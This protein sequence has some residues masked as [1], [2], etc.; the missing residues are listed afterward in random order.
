MAWNFLNKE[1]ITPM[2]SLR[3]GEEKWGQHFSF[4]SGLDDLE[5]SEAPF[6]ILGVEEDFGVLGNHGVGGTQ[7]AWKN[8]LPVLVNVQENQFLSGKDVI[9]LGSYKPTK[10]Y[11]TLGLQATPE[12]ARKAVETVDAEVGAAVEKIVGAGKIP[13]LI[14]GGHNNAYPLLAGTS[15]GLK[16]KI[17]AINLDPHADFR[18]LEGRHSGNGFSYAKDEG[19]L[20]NYF[21]LGLHQNYNSDEMIKR[22]LATPGFEVHFQDHWIQGKGSLV[23]SLT[24]FM[25]RLPEDPYGVELD[26]DAIEYMPTSAITPSG[27]SLNDARLYTRTTGAHKN[28]R[29]LH[30]PEGRPIGEATADK[31]LAKATTYLITDFI[32][33]KNSKR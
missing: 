25:E 1:D 4:V 19:F 27:V 14:G 31:M 11:E 17:N 6:V 10:L 22:L 2:L 3:E 5:S 24:S 18:P 33:A 7:K 30:L 16:S 9:L 20:N 21:L 28:A 29:Y 8:L 23:G 15:K 26:L 12:R 13:I 32:K